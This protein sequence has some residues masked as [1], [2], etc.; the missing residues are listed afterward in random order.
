MPTVVDIGSADL[1][2]VERSAE[3]GAELA[4]ATSTVIRSTE[5]DAEEHRGFMA[6]SRF[7]MGLAVLAEFFG[8]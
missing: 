8:Q 6:S 5:P 4:E 3:I 7:C 1:R 2:Y